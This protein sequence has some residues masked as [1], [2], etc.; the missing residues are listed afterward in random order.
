MEITIS[1]PEQVFASISNAA[2]KSHKSVDKI[3]AERIERDFSVEVE[4]LAQQIASC[5]DTEVLLLAK[6]HIGAKQDDRLHNLLQKQGEMTL[7]ANDQR[8]LWNLM[9]LNR[10]ATLKKAFAL[11]EITRRNLNAHAQ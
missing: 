8:D 6:T 10:L 11:R 2:S 5:S 9:D 3:I 1:L 7:S 4:D